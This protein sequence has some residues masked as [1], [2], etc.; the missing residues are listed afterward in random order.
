MRERPERSLNADAGF[1][2]KRPSNG[3][4]LTYIYADLA[5]VFAVTRTEG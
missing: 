3:D 5:G 4:V 1:F 2:R